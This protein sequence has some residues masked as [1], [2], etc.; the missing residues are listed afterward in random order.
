MSEDNEHI[1]GLVLQASGI[2][3][4]AHGKVKIMQA[5]I[6]VGFTT[7]ERQNMT[8]YQQVRRKATKV[9]I[10]DHG[11][12]ATIATIALNCSN[13]S[14]VSGLTTDLSGSSNEKASIE[15][16]DDDAEVEVL[17][18]L[19][20]SLYHP[21]PIV[22]DAS[23]V[24]GAAPESNKKPRAT[25]KAVQRKHAIKARQKHRDKQA[26]KQVTVLIDRNNKLPL[27]HPEKT[28]TAA[29]VAT[30]NA[31]LNANVSAKTAAEYVCNGL[32]GVSTLKRGPVS[33]FPLQVW[34]SLKGAF[35]T[36]LKLEQAGT[37][38]Q[39][40]IKCWLYETY[41]T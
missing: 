32:I 34:T 22:I 31:R 29:L 16:E 21:V 37:K 18:I 33:E 25:S 27:N 23:S 10:V 26:M 41:G 14:S 7:P 8:L 35:V 6:L 12:K 20:S 1:K 3:A 40:T 13:G 38:K 9:S 15:T 28:L 24:G 19:P 2:V 17:G 11:K 4:A 5:M 39:S 30:T 36:Y